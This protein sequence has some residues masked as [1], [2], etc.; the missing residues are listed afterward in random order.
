MYGSWKIIFGLMDWDDVYIFYTIVNK[1][2][3]DKNLISSET[4]L[5]F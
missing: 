4:T 1:N 3:N 5:T 2:V